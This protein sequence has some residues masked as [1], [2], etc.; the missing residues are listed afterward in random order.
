[1][2]FEQMSAIRVHDPARTAELRRRYLA[3][4]LDALRPDAASASLPGAA[5][6]ESELGER[7]ATD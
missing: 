3:L 5:P 1:M 6:S 4:L 7:W 2:L